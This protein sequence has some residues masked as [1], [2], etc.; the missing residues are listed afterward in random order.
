MIA[1]HAVATRL[2][3]ALVEGGQG[4]SNPRCPRVCHRRGFCDSDLHRHPCALLKPIPYEHGER[5]VS[6]LGAT[7]D[8]PKGLSS[9]T[10]KDALEYEQRARS[11]DLFGWF[12]FNSYNLTAPGEPQFVK[13]V[14]VTPPLVNGIGV[15][16]RL[17]RWFTDAS[18]PS[19]VLSH[20]LWVRLGA[21]PAMVGKTLP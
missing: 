20:D 21:D 2:S 17:G 6:V 7:F 8:D 10:T 15:N 1:L 9:V 18:V 5:F 11:F 19:A 3:V 12:V 4:S 16:P 14:E 13:G